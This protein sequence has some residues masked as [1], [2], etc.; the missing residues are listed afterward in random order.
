MIYSG[1]TPVGEFFVLREFAQR[2]PGAVAPDR[3]AIA[4]ARLCCAA[5]D[6]VRRRYGR[7]RINSGYRTRA[8][9]AAVGGATASHHLYDLLPDTP[10]ADFRCASGTPREWAAFLD[11]L[12]KGRWGIG[13]YSTHVH[14][15]RRDDRARW[16][17]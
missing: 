15:D 14:V 17:G 16:N 11:D 3:A 9:N 13:V 7:T 5:L 10:A 12:S 4:I 1:S 2:R 6:P 8:H